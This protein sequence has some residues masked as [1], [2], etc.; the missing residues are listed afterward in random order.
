[1]AAKRWG[2][3]KEVKNGLNGN[4]QYTQTPVHTNLAYRW[5]DVAIIWGLEIRPEKT[6]SVH[7]SGVHF[8]LPVCNCICTR[9]KTE[10]APAGITAEDFS[11]QQSRALHTLTIAHGPD[12]FSLASP[13]NHCLFEAFALK[14]IH[15][16]FHTG[17]T[18]AGTSLLGRDAETNAAAPEN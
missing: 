12:G 5:P 14:V 10:I 7:L 13:W 9:L 3:Y 16:T 2:E 6:K 17:C 15:A 11:R 18:M 4:K 8:T 1:M